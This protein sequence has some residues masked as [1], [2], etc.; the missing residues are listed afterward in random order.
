MRTLAK[1]QTKIIATLGPSS[2]SPKVFEKLVK[3]GINVARLNFAHGTH[4][5]HAKSIQTVRRIATK[6]QIPI[7]LLQDLPGP[8]LRVGVLPDLSTTL[9]QEEGVVLISSHKS[10]SKKI[11]PV[12]YPNLTKDL[13]P[14]HVVYI[15]DG[16]IRLSVQ[17]VKSGQV[18]CVVANGGTVR[19]GNGINMPYSSLNLGAFTKEDERHLEF[20]LKNQVD[21]V[22]VSFVGRANDLDRVRSFCQ[23]HGKN[24]FLIAKIERRQALRHLAGI[25]EKADGLMVARGDLGVEFPF[26]Q[27]PGLQ[28]DIVS[29]AHQ[30]GKPVI[31]ATQVLESM[32][33]NPRPTRAEATDIA[34]AII[35]GTDAIML[36]GETSIGKKSG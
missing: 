9:R 33:Q 28:N 11:I 13:K 18:Q 21:F 17:S 32:I 1:I 36:S 8:K 20:G 15:A 5:E 35:E 34:N 2:A 7:G 12:P 31:V 22:G 25:L 24:P 3:E 29:M 23:N 30:K 10:V 4:S 19:T 14:G 6:A 26:S 27:I 16:L